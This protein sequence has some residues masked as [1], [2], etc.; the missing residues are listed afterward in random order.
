MLLVAA[1]SMIWRQVRS[2]CSQRRNGGFEQLHYSKLRSSSLYHS[3]L[4]SSQF[5]EIAVSLRIRPIQELPF[6]PRTSLSQQY[7]FSREVCNALTETQLLRSVHFLKKGKLNEHPGKFMLGYGRG[8][9]PVRVLV[10]ALALVLA[11]A[12]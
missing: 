5:D 12:R 2:G 3:E 7:V 11:L 4:R 9:K 6:A 8:T 10:V 1:R